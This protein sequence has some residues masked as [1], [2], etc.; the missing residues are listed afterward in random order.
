MLSYFIAITLAQLV[1]A[2]GAQWPERCVALQI[3][4]C[5][6]QSDDK[7]Y[8]SVN[9]NQYFLSK[10]SL[11]EFISPNEVRLMK[12]I[13]WV[14]SENKLQMSSAFGVI[15]THSKS[16]FIF[17]Q[18]EQTHQITVSV[19]SGEL[20]VMARADKESYLLSEGMEVDM[21]PVDY[22]RKMASVSLPKVISLNRYL[23]SIERVFPFSEFNFQEHIDL[24]AQSIHRALSRQSK[25]N[26][27]IVETKIADANER[28]A[29]Q[30]YEAEYSSRRDS[31]L[32]K[33]FR[34]KNNFEE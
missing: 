27:T 31:Y 4:P 14:K 23:K 16:E 11:I 13:V 34:Q 30:K 6:V 33:L 1:F 9:Q 12:G 19:L 10:K 5:V 29:R 8:F 18:Q 26:K 32:K 2:G 25:W 28:K 24:M 15:S 21:G 20:N 22:E 3:Y 7:I 17:S